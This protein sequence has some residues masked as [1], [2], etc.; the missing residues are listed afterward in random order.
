MFSLGFWVQGSCKNFRPGRKGKKK[1]SFFHSLVHMVVTLARNSLSSSNPC[2]NQ[3]LVV[4]MVIYVWG[5]FHFFYFHPYPW[6]NDPIWRA[7]CSN[8]LKPPTICHLIV[9]II[10]IIRKWWS[11]D[12]HLAFDRGI[13]F[14]SDY[15]LIVII[16]FYRL[17][18][19]Y[20]SS[21][22]NACHLTMMCKWCKCVFFDSDRHLPPES[23]HLK[24]QNSQLLHRYEFL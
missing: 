1:L 13:S 11:F 3:L 22:D 2:T 8:G 21:F 19:D 6:G 5:W 14:D 24:H 15:H 23:W 17:S 10:T 18:F 7:Y 16:M 9:T 20:D 12:H 4:T